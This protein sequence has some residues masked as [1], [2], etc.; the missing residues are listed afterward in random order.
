MVPWELTLISKTNAEFKTNG[1]ATGK[2][3]VRAVVDPCCNGQR[4]R[5]YEQDHLPWALSAQAVP[6]SGALG[7]TAW[8]EAKLGNWV[9]VTV[10]LKAVG[11]AT[12]A[13]SKT[14]EIGEVLDGIGV[15]PNSEMGVVESSVETNEMEPKLLLEKTAVEAEMDIGAASRHTIPRNNIYT[16][17]DL[18]CIDDV[19]YGVCGMGL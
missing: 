18:D 4:E 10:I 16:N 7:L 12:S 1:N 19:A 17:N 8:E 15:K 3:Q 9:E 6:L 11:D 2:I 5:P 14:K 13:K